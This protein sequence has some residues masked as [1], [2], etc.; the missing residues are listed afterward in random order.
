[1]NNKPLISVLMGIY[2]C[3]NTLQAAVESI[4][5]QTYENWELIMCDDC[6]TDNTYALAKQI[7]ESD[8]RIKVIKNNTNLTLAPTL[9]NCLAVAKGD[10]TARM[11][12]DDT[13]DNRRF[14][15]E[16][17]F[18]LKN[19][20]Y[21]VVSTKMNL[22]DNDGVFRTTNVHSFPKA[23]ELILGPPFCHAGCM[24]KKSVLDELGGYNT[25]EDVQRVE[26][27]DLW[28]RLYKSGYKGANLQDAL[29][30]MRDDRKAVKR[31]KMKYRVNSYRI[32]KNIIKTFNLSAKYYLYAVRPILIG[33]IPTFAYKTL[34]RGK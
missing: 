15:K 27:Y 5:N 19:P 9:N 13:C 31:R 28:Y 10:Y 6:S 12:G 21:A 1:M 16:L 8:S 17:D 20:D 34:H 25:S 26:D 18:L 23:T 24:M 22:F 33:L 29:Y 7:A 30:F 32:R 14:E 2:N 4:K 11:D 3:E